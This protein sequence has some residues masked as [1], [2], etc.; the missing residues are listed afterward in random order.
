MSESSSASSESFVCVPQE[1]Y[2]MVK[3]VMFFK[4]FSVHTLPARFYVFIECQ[5]YIVCVTDVVKKRF[6]VSSCVTSDK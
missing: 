3:M 4:I 5:R 6:Q 2:V 1:S